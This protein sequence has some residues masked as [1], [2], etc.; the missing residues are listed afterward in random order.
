MMMIKQGVP[1]F[2][3][4]EEDRFKFFSGIEGEIAKQQSELA[5]FKK[6]KQ[7]ERQGMEEQMKKDKL[8][9]LMGIG[10]E[11]DSEEE[12][13]YPDLWD[14]SEE[15]AKDEKQQMIDKMQKL[16]FANGMGVAGDRTNW[17]KLPDPTVIK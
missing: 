11:K 6:K 14:D 8:A 13:N 4:K 3:H 1:Q 12:E 10:D 16:G 9:A 7:M 5:D 15:E 2:L 17:L